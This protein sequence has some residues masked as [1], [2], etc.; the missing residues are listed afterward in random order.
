VTLDSCIKMI[1]KARSS[2]LTVPVV[3]MGY[4]NPF[5]VVWFRKT[6]G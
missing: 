2:G 1:A 3:L 4:F 5:F 6:H